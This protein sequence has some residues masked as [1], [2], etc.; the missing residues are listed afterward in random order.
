MEQREERRVPLPLLLSI[1]VASMVV[2]FAS[3][4][5]GP[6]LI[7]HHPL[8]Q[9]ALNPRNRWLLLASPQIGAVPFYV[10]GFLRLV[11][12][13]PVGYVLGYQYGDAAVAWAER[14]MGDTEGVI[15]MI[16]R[17]FGRVAPLVILIAPS[18]YWCVLAGAARMRLRLFISLNIIGTIGRLVLFRIA[19]DAFRDELESVLDWIQR[20]QWWLV[21]LSLLVVALQIFRGRERGTLE[22]PLEMAAEIEA[23]EE[24]LHD[25]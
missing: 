16:Q 15:K 25:E 11:S 6:T 24:S 23:E 5:A 7:N 20:Y 10:V 2:G 14:Q 4:I 12:T 21:G 22:S 18:F 9:I 3:D 1:F 8:L 13:D 19:G 17:G